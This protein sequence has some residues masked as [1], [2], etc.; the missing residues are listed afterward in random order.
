MMKKIKILYITRKYPPQIGGMENFSYHLYHHFPSDRAEKTII[1]LGKSQKN[2]IWFLPYALIRTLLT[3]KKYDIIFVGDALLSSIGFFT[4][5]FYKNKIT[6]V[7]VFGL[8]IT[9][10]NPLYQFYLKLFYKRFD[11]YISISRETDNALHNKGN[12]DSVVITPGVDTERFNEKSTDFQVLRK[13]YDLAENDMIL[14]TVGRLVKRK[15]VNWFVRNVMPQLADK[16]IKYLIIGSGEEHDMIRDS[17]NEFHL[18]DK[19]RL[20]GYVENEALNALYLHADAFIM[21]NIVVEGDMEGFGLVAVEASLAGLIV[22]ASGI[23]GI[24]DAISDGKN[25][26]LI[27]SGNADAFV[28]KI[29]S[30]YDS[31]GANT[32]TSEMFRQYTLDHYSW[33]AICGQY[34]A[35]FEKMLS[36]KGE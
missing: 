26:F 35:L 2:L 27:E 22:I 7:N 4:K 14:I 36:E 5:L 30:L 20:L 8:D 15:G 17:I 28:N 10:K 29:T 13:K 3:A 21:P 24:K 12:F 32:E 11:K 1:S 34:I 33:D 23:E 6:V 16:P 18:E 31:R 9:F 19:V 25:G